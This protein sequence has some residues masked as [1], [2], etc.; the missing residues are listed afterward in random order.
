MRGNKTSMLLA[1]AAIIG[2]TAGAFMP[3]V[4]DPM[5]A[6]SVPSAYTHAPRGRSHGRHKP[7]GAKLARRAAQGKVGRASIR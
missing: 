3:A 4:P 1:A 6:G 7:A 5:R 2:T